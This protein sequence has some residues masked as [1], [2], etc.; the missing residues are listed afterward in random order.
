M[1]GNENTIMVILNADGTQSIAVMK[2]VGDETKGLADKTKSAMDNIQQY[3]AVYAGAVGIAYAAINKVTSTFEETI[4]FQEQKSALNSLATQ[5][6]STSDQIIS[7]VQRL[8]GGIIS[9]SDAASAAAK[10][11]MMGLDPSQLNKFMEIVKYTAPAMGMEIGD[12][13]NSIT[14][15]IALGN[16]RILRRHLGVMIDVQQVYKDYAV[17]IGKDV[18]QLKDF[19]RQNALINAVLEKQGD[20]VNRLKNQHQ[21]NIDAAVKEVQRL[22]TNWSDLGENAGRIGIQL[23]EPIVAFTALIAKAFDSTETLEKAYERAVQTGMGIPLTVTGNKPAGMSVDEFEMIKNQAAERANSAAKTDKEYTD[24]LTRQKK[25]RNDLL[26]QID[27]DHDRAVLVEKEK[28]YKDVERILMEAEG[29]ASEVN[30]TA[31]E[32]ALQQLLNK[33][34]MEKTILLNAQ[35]DKDQID[36]LDAAHRAEYD[37]L[38]RVQ[39]EEALKKQVELDKQAARKKESE[40]ERFWKAQIAL[41]DKNQKEQND[42]WERFWRH[43]IDLM[44][45]QDALAFRDKEEAVRKYYSDLDS[46]ASKSGLKG[47]NDYVKAQ[48]NISDIYRRGLEHRKAVAESH[49]QSTYDTE[50]K[51]AQ[52]TAD[53]KIDI[54]QNAA[55]VL[56][57]LSLMVSQMSRDHG[58][59]AFRVYKDFAIAQAMISTYESATKS[60]DSMAGIPYV[61]PALGIAAAAVAIGMGLAQVAAIKAQEP[62][63][64]GGAPAGISGGGY[65]YANPT[66]PS[67]QPTTNNVNNQRTTEVNIH[68][69][70]SVVDYDKFAREIVPAITK[71]KNDGVQ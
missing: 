1:V 20:I 60:Y 49:G 38:R 28:H 47:A 17:S 23:A 40:W 10:G 48:Q 45:R 58:D 64:G 35:A 11:L 67:L 13:F 18:D 42:L 9:M 57:N 22:K 41:E 54:A 61:G 25:E 5:Y 6:G 68:V 71:A 31:S 32:K 30:M 34:A 53:Q 2:Q 24:M 50:V 55:G 21:D 27:R 62:G 66:A 65:A 51:W 3:W 56:A 26:D 39:H 12:A 70:G 29:R 46:L 59:K 43:Q 4:K 7:D 52:L 33:Q 14:Q 63:G 16:E 69:Y 37:E 19:E 15:A 8:S 36:K 44:N